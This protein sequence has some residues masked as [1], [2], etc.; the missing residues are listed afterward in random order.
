MAAPLIGDANTARKA[1]AAVDDEH[2]A[3]GAIVDRVYS[4]TSEARDN[5]RPGSPQLSCDQISFSSIRLL[6]T[7]SSIT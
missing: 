4:S 5:A 7:Q 2:L 3:M 6:P 1:E